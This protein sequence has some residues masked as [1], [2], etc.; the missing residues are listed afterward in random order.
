MRSSVR[1]LSPFFNRLWEARA[2]D[3]ISADISQ[4]AISSHDKRLGIC[5]EYLEHETEYVH[6]MLRL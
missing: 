4:N 1:C 5:I 2:G 6:L 3:L